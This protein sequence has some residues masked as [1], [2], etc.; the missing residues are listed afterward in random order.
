[1]GLDMKRRRWMIFDTLFLGVVG[2]FSA[3]P[4]CRCHGGGRDGQAFWATISGHGG[5]GHGGGVRRCGPK[6]PG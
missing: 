4:V 3:H 5:C 2:A 6:A 1:M